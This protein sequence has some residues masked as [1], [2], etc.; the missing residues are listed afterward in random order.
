MVSQAPAVGRPAPARH[1]RYAGLFSALKK[2]RWSISYVALLVYLVVI[3]TY[4]WAGIG[5]YVMGLALIALAVEM[6]VRMTPVLALL[7]LLVIWA[8][9]THY[10]SPW[11]GNA[12]STVI[13]AGKVWL[14]ALVATSNLTERKRV[15]LFMLVFVA[16]FA[17]YP[18]RG[19]LFNY[20]LGGYTIF[21]R[22]LWNYIYSNP[23]DLAALAL[24]Q[25]SLAAAIYVAEPA[26]WYRKGAIAALVV[27]PIVV[28]LT[29]SRGAFVGLLM[30]ALLTF[31]TQ[32]RKARLLGFAAVVAL[33]AYLILP[34]TALERF[35]MVRTIGMGGSETL[36][37]LDDQG[38]AQQRYEIWQTARRII[39]DNPLTGVG[40]GNYALANGTY[41]PELGNR[42]SHSTYLNLLAEVGIP[43]FLIF[44]SLIGVTIW[45]AEITR[46]QVRARNPVLSQQIRFLELGLA[47]FLLAGIFASYAKLTFLY[48]QLVLIWALTDLARRELRPP[49]R[50]YRRGVG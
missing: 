6:K 26:G 4:V 28:L 36:G 11:P 32:R 13:T 21:G 22:A 35:T 33:A 37:A 12:R 16:A 9:L 40:Y 14:V 48:V 38:S 43:G 10:S 39:A 3:T 42:D 45:R 41:S 47:G 7:G 8:F 46:R 31:T 1:K 15:R 24:L 30:F 5:P 20:F 17:M 27:L 18:A 29:Q 50:A 34:D 19:A 49:A 2:V 44:A 23:N 25:V